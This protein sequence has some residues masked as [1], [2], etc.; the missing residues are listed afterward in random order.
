MSDASSK[1]FA[2]IVGVEGKL[3]LDPNDRGNWTSG[4]VGIGFLKGSKYGISAATYPDLD[5]ANLSSADA[6][7]IFES[8]YWTAIRGDEL[9][10]SLALCVADDAYNHGPGTA[11]QTLQHALGVAVDGKLGN[12]TVAATHAANL[13][14]LVKTFQGLRGVAYAGD[15]N[16][17]KYGTDWFRERVV[18]TAIEAFS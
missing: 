6:Q 8:K 9:P 12:G 5:I 3:S 10:Y 1:A 4:R 11:T 13:R 7:K 16:V 2:Y 18:G 14:T 17:S 15:P